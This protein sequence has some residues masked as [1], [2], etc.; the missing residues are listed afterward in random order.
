MTRGRSTTPMSPLSLDKP[1]PSLPNVPT[2]VSS[3]VSVHEFEGYL[4]M[5]AY[6]QRGL[7]PDP[8]TGQQGKPPSKPPSRNASPVH[9]VIRPAPKEDE[10]MSTRSES[11]MSSANTTT[12][13]GDEPRR[14]RSRPPNL[15]RS[16][17]NSASG[18]TVTPMSSLESEWEPRGVKGTLSGPGMAPRIEEVSEPGTASPTLTPQRHSTVAPQV[19]YY[20]GH[21]PTGKDARRRSGSPMTVLEMSRLVGH[22]TEEPRE[23]TEEVKRTLV[24]TPEPRA[25]F[26]HAN[27]FVRPS[28]PDPYASN[29]SSPDEV[30]HKRKL[31]EIEIKI[32]DEGKTIEDRENVTP[33][34]DKRSFYERVSSREPSALQ[35]SPANPKE[36]SEGSEDERVSCDENPNTRSFWKN[37]DGVILV[38]Q[39]INV[40]GEEL[41]YG[42]D[43]NYL[44]SFRDDDEGSSD[45]G[46]TRNSTHD[47]VGTGEGLAMIPEVV[48]GSDE[49]WDDEAFEA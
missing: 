13:S 28:N 32:E 4:D 29:F 20:C 5:L 47:L 3:D 12:A 2:W 19:C 14:H 39:G 45:L 48:G 41:Y 23:E 8:K 11:Q 30:P 25:A 49:L 9:N 22:N 36:N 18:K 1:L 42:S 21:D 38:Y 17:S 26:D 37:P 7:P 46:S 43:I 24:R 44:G 40:E 35:G 33:T 15:A 27:S 34:H 16:P 10:W 31:A 6:S